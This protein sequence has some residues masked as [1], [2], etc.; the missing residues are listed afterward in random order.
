MDILYIKTLSL[1]HSM[2]V[3]AQGYVEH[4]L[5]MHRYCGSTPD[6]PHIQTMYS[7]PFLIF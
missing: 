1:L 7:D 6:S 5:S 4:Q 3:A 2:G